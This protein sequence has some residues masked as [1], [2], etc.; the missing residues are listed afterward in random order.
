MAE[1]IA[2]MRLF[3]GADPHMVATTYTMHSIFNKDLAAFT[4]FD[5]TFDAQWAADWLVDIEAAQRLISDNVVIDQVAAETEK[6]NATMQA[7][8][9]KWTEIKYFIKK[10]FP[11]DAAMLHV[12]G[13]SAYLK[14]R[15]SQPKMIEFL[16][17]LHTAATDNSAQL[18]A[19]GYSQSRIDEIEDIC[20]ALSTKNDAQ[21]KARRGRP[22]LTAQRIAALNAP[23]V[24]MMLVNEAAQIVFMGNAAKR[25]QYMYRTGQRKK[26]KDEAQEGQ[27]A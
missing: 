6:V 14:A 18:I 2:L 11:R 15:M 26:K 16:L 7:G 13:A 22:R 4:D 25:R 21:N 9:D 23:Y 10:A 24:K 12:F 20:T 17:G 3:R 1:E 27:A 19:A 8:R 5:S